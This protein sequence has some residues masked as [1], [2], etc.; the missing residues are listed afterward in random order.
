MIPPVRLSAPRSLPRRP[1]TPQPMVTSA[2]NWLEQSGGESIRSSTGH[3]LHIGVSTCREVLARR[4]RRAPAS[5][6]RR[7]SVS[8]GRARDP[9]HSRRAARRFLDA[10]ASNAPRRAKRRT[11]GKPRGRAGWGRPSSAVNGRARVGA[12]M[13]ARQRD[14]GPRSRRTSISAA[15]RRISACGRWP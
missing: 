3:P 1:Y 10:L 15:E 11:R 9:G 14:P 13:S 12:N 6:R 5:R 7:S 2:C 4:P 8:H